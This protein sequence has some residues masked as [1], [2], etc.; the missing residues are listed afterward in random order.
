MDAAVA[1]VAG[2]VP[3]LHRKNARILWTLVG[4]SGLG[5]VRF[6]SER[7]YSRPQT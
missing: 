3:A 6:W 1:A 2:F 7:G 4:Y 5:D